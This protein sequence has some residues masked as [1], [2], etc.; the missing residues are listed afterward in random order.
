MRGVLVVSCNALLNKNR[1]VIIDTR[2][3]YL[4]FSFRAQKSPKRLD[5]FDRL[6]SLC[7]VWQKKKKTLAHQDE[8]LAPVHRAETPKT[9]PR[10]ASILLLL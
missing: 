4:S 7:D 10:N 6:V 2:Q 8:R 9:P 5:T 3:K 1:H